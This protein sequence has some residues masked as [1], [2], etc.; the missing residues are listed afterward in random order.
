[1]VV[2]W[3]CAHIICLSVLVSTVIGW[4]LF[5]YITNRKWVFH[6]TVTVFQDVMKER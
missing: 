2:Y 1:M 5:A 4:I 3:Y 6:S